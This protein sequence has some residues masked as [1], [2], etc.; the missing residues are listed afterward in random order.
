[1][2]STSVV[3][4][5]RDARLADNPAWS[6]GTLADRVC[7]LFVID[8]VIFDAVSVRR[9]T[10]LVGGLRALDG[11]LRNI[12]GRLRVEHGDPRV[13]VP[14]V[15]AELGA[16]VVH[17]NAEV[18]PYGRRR[19]RAVRKGVHLEEHDGV[20]IHPPGS[21][22]TAAGTP[23]RVFAPFHRRWSDLP[24]PM[25]GEPGAAVPTTDAGV[26]FP[27]GS[28][29]PIAAGEAAA[30]DRL[31]GFLRRV[32]RYEDDRDRFGLNATSHLSIDL[33]Y[34]WIGARTVLTA[35]AGD[36][37]GRRSFARQLAW[38]DFYGGLLAFDPGLVWR[39]MRSEHDAIAWRDDPGELTA[40]QT[41]TTGYP[42]VD[43]AMRQLVADGWIHNRLRMLTASFLVKDLLIDWRLGERFFRRHLLDGDVAQN[44]GNWQWVAGTGTDAAPYFRIF[45]PTAQSRRFDPG[46]GYIRRWV[47]E[48]ATLP[49]RHVHA[50]WEAPANELAAAGVVLGDTYP[51]PLVD[52]AAARR[53]ALD[54]YGAVKRVD[55][56]A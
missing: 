4:F 32:D 54:A 46:G 31:D 44:A 24:I 1:M 10:L 34:G 51:E 2:T 42:I 15:A 29:P 11:R 33:K 23:Y 8:P 39:S 38:R 3:W 47:P 55:A 13:V 17:V 43:A 45:N 40:W 25:V 18:T 6:E 53:R 19:D 9:R 41:G 48:L 21:V 56:C 27:G 22:L 30:L 26:G 52:H 14:A 49:D 35:I 12:G 37:A 16:P 20:Y 7:P 5:R 36:A 50:P 28:A